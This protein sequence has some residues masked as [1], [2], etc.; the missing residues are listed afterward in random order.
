MGEKLWG[1]A[2][3]VPSYEDTFQVLLLQAASDGRGDAL[4]GESQARARE[5]VPPFLLGKDFPDIYLE[6]P[7]IGEPFLDVTILLNKLEPGTRV[8]SPAA[9]EHGAMLDWYAEARPTYEN[10]SCGFE[11]DTKETELP[12]AAVHF[13]PRWHKELVEPFCATI[14]EPERA[15]LYLDLDARM[16]QGWSLSFFGMFRGRPAAPLRVCG[17]L[18]GNEQRACAEDS[19]HV[20]QVFDAVGFT[21]Y[22][23]PMLEQI[24]RLM[25]STPGSIDF[26][27]DVYPDGHIGDVFAIDVQFDIQQPAVVQASFETGPGARVM[28][29][30]EEWGAAD[31]RWRLAPHAAF[32]RALPVELED[33]ELAGYAFTLMP[34]WAKVR[35]TNCELQP[36]KLYHLAHGGLLDKD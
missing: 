6:H 7:L 13:Q 32:A 22:D 2:M 33:G 4:F 35:W 15:Q 17:Y 16:P 9:G 26:Q 18:P 12:M 14:G 34:Q 36:S 30:L 20:A 27:F 1:M 11:L 3:R 24:A 5:A 10:I 21:A 25:A 28:E 29:L 8:D 31:E 19:A 23:Q